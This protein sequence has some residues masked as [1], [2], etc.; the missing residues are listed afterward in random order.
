[1]RIMFLEGFIIAAAGLS[2][3]PDVGEIF[4]AEG[5]A[6]TI[7]CYD[8]INGNA[9]T[10]WIDYQGRN[11]SS[12]ATEKLYQQGVENHATLIFRNL[13]SKE[14]GF[15]SC[16][17]NQNRPRNIRRFN[18]GVYRSPVFAKGFDQQYLIEARQSNV[19]CPIIAWPKPT[20]EWTFNRT[21]VVEDDNQFFSTDRTVLFIRKPTEDHQGIY[22]CRATQLTKA[23]SHLAE[24][25]ISVDV[26]YRPNILHK[27]R[28]VIPRHSVGP[29]S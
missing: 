17:T 26:R 25:S 4:K 20:I 10:Y 21:R 2:F 5:T 19:T 7:D 15:Y 28:E 14:E 22:R 27:Q 24:H 16:R 8:T 1:M 6:F 12:N 13:S 3:V 18:V 29:S 23:Y 9:K 11:I